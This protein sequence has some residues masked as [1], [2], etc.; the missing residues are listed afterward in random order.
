MI[1]TLSPPKIKEEFQW[2][3]PLVGSTLVL[4][5]ILGMTAVFFPKSC[6]KIFHGNEKGIGSNSNVL[7]HR[8]EYFQ[9]SCRIFTITL[10]HGHHPICQ[11]FLHHEFQIDK[12]TFCTACMG[13]FSGAIVSIFGVVAY[14][15]LEYPIAKYAGFFVTFGVAGVVLGL[16]QYIFLDFRRKP[17]RFFLNAFFIFGMFL[18]LV[19]IDND[20]QSLVLDFFLI[21]L[22]V[23]WLFTR[24]LLSKWQHTKICSACDLDCSLKEES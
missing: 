18:I 21:S 20:V 22:F 23:F 6:S 10:T 17:I 19:G 8:K 2:R 4:I 13:L 7:F 1:I 12:K 14:F 15:F 3:K 5:Y 9:K 11:G 16:L 24:I